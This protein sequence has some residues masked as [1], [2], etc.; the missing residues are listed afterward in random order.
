MSYVLGPTKAAPN[1]MFMQ[2]DANSST[3]DAWI[4]ETA[5]QPLTQSEHLEKKSNG[6]PGKVVARVKKYLVNGGFDMKF[7]RDAF[8]SALQNRLSYEEFLDLVDMLNLVVSKHRTKKADIVGLFALSIFYMGPFMHRKK[9]RSKKRKVETAEVLLQFNNEHQ[10]LR[11]RI[12]RNTGD[13][14]FQEWILQ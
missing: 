14:E 5:D 6:Y 4:T 13:L 9:K 7:D 11:A 2:N 3:D 12:N 8:P 10:H 1:T